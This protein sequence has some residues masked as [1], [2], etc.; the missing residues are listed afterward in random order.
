MRKTCIEFLNLIFISFM[1]SRAYPKKICGNRRH[2][3]HF[4]WGELWGKI[5]NSHHVTLK[6]IWKIIVDFETWN[7]C[8][9]FFSDMSWKS[10]ENIQS[11]MNNWLFN[12]SLHLKMY[13]IVHICRV[14]YIEW[15]ESENTQWFYCVMSKSSGNCLEYECSIENN[16]FRLKICGDGEVQW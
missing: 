10:F 16:I 11:F 14:M 7:W 3:N 9:H 2:L 15:C 13:S 8:F 5:K 1:H 4:N 6:M 12:L